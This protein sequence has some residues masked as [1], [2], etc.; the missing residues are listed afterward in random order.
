M[1]SHLADYGVN[2]TVVMIEV[3]SLLVSFRHGYND[4]IVLVSQQVR[5][6]YNFPVEADCPG[7]LSLQEFPT[8]S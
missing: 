4:P 6:V 7:W 3:I 2:G 1:P 8:S 5:N